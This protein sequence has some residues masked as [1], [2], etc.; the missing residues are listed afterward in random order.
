MAAVVKI[1]GLY[2]NP[3]TT[4][5]LTIQ[6]YNTAIPGQR[7]PGLSF[8]NNMPTV[9]GTV[10]R[11][12]WQFTG[13]QV[14]GGTYSQLSYWRWGTSGAEKSIWGLNNGMI[15]VALKDSGAPGCPF[16]SCIP[17]TGIQD[18]FGY[19]IKDPDHGIPFYINETTPCADSDDYRPDNPLVFCADVIT[20]EGPSHTTS[21]VVTQLVLAYNSTFG[22][23][24]DLSRFFRWREI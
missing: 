9:E 12:C 4:T 16:A 13:C 20:P 11:S 3:L 17:P 19:D 2:G 14:T 1:V 5:E 21:F 6:R 8:P 23:N 24:G 18:Q 10:S 15:Q 7:D 22:E